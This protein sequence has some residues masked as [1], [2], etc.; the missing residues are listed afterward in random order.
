MI[1][2]ALKQDSLFFAAPAELHRRVKAELRSEFGIKPRSNVWNWNWLTA[3]ATGMATACLA[4][5]FCPPKFQPLTWPLSHE[6]SH[7]SLAA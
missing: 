1:S 2:K 3:A 5:L 4:L 6:I 7:Y